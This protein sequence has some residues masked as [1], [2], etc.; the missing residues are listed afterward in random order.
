ML[1]AGSSR[2]GGGAAPGPQGQTAAVSRWDLRSSAGAGPGPSSVP[3]GSRAG[4]RWSPLGSGIPWRG[5][6]ACPG[7]CC[8]TRAEARGLRLDPAFCPLL[9]PGRARAASRGPRARRPGLA[10]EVAQESP[11][12]A[13]P[14]QAESRRPDGDVETG[15]R[16][17]EVT[18]GEAGPEAAA[19]A[20]RRGWRLRRSSAL[21]LSP[22]DALTVTPA[23][24]WLPLARGPRRVP[25]GSPE[26]ERG[27]RRLR[28][29]AGG[30]RREHRLRLRLR[31]PRRHVAGELH[32]GARLGPPASASLPGSAGTSLPGVPSAPR[33]RGSPR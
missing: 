30:A 15:R 2:G 33:S 22:A 7:S 23:A 8:D 25:G 19:P 21:R 12:A 16:D 4:V 29:D 9:P 5:P 11:L 13:A 27:T 31:L 17:S 6:R 1:H 24:W 32:A 10:P 3:A 18:G 26:F 28:H 20:A 14:R